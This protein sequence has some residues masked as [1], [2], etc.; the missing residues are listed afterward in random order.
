M[1][2]RMK[3]SAILIF[4]AV[5]TTVSLCRGQSGWV[6]RG[7]FNFGCNVNLVYGKGQKF[8][9]G[10]LFA[11]FIANAVYNDHFILNY[12]PS[13]SIYTKTLGAN[14]NPIVNDIQIDLINSFSIGVGGDALAYNKFFRTM[15]NAPYYNVMI[16]QNYAALLTTNFILN[17]HKRNQVNGALTLSSPYVTLNYYN[18]GAFPFDLVAIADNFDRYWTGG[19]CLFVHT[20]QNYNSV[21]FSFD[22]FTGYVPLLYEMTTRL[23]INLPN[24]NAGD[25]SKLNTGFN[26]SA[27]NIRVFPAQGFGMDA[28]ILGALKSNTGR[29]FGLQE[30]IHTMG[31]YAQHPNNDVTRFYFGGTY[32]NMNNVRFK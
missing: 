20:D 18:D 10:R 28:G 19:I 1:V 3:K 11:G 25:T 8:P 4:F 6:Y 29:M 13:L 22:Q 27:F 30:I 17:N 14:L 26:T 21:E 9:G 31:N 16:S 5:F 32:N 2:Y 7:H 12:G 24:Y 15:G 23:G